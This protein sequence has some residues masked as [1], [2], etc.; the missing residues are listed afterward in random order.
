M[1]ES[2]WVIERYIR[3]D[4]YYWDGSSEVQ[5]VGFVKEAS[6]AVRFSRE[7]DAMNVLCRLLNGHGRVAQHVFVG[8]PAPGGKE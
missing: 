5:N 1:N 2:G 6:S 4:L 8:E 3:S 7:E